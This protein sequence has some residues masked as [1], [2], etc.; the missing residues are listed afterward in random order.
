MSDV[1]TAMKTFGAEWQL[2]IRYQDYSARVTNCMELTWRVTTGV[3][4]LSC[5]NIYSLYLLNLA[6]F[7]S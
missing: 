4:S 7:C 3:N 2:G 6:T 1:T 5:G